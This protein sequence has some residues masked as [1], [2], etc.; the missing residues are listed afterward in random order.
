MKKE[1]R[2]N[3]EAKRN[4]EFFIFSETGLSFRLLAKESVANETRLDKPRFKIPTEL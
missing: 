2:R 1:E 4:N 3:R